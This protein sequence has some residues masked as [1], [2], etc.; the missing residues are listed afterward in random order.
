MSTTTLSD[1]L[2]ALKSMTSDPTSLATLRK[3]FKGSVTFN[4]LGKEDKTT[5]VTINLKKGYTGDVVTIGG[6][7]EKV[8]LVVGVGEDDYMK[9]IE[10]KLNP[11]EG[12]CKVVCLLL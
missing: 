7:G 4:I 1:V 2:S 6:Q 5:S 11:Q 10:G 12:A 8:D 3:K 9:M